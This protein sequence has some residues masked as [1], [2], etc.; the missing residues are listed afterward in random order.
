MYFEA[1]RP[2]TVNSVALACRNN[3]VEA[4]KVMISEGCGRD[5]LRHKDN[6]GWEPIHEPC[7][8]GAIESLRILLEEDETEI[9]AESWAGETGLN[10]AASLQNR[11]QVAKVLLE[12]GCDV[13]SSDEMGI[14]PLHN[15]TIRL[16]RP[17]VDLLTERG[18]DV[19]KKSVWNTTSLHS[20]FKK[21][22][23]EDES[24]VVYILKKLVKHG[25]EVDSGDEN[26][27]TPL[28]IAAEKG[29]LEVCKFLLDTNIRLLNMEAE[30]GANALMLACQNGHAEVVD[31]LLAMSDAHPEYGI[32]V[33]RRASDGAMALHLAAEAKAKSSEIMKMV[34]SRTDKDQ[35]LS[36][37]K[38]SPYHIALEHKNLE[39][40]S[41]LANSN[42]LHP[43]QFHVPIDYVDNDYLIWSGYS[44]LNSLGFLLTN[45]ASVPESDLKKLL[46]DLEP[47][48]ADN[49]IQSLPPILAIVLHREGFHRNLRRK[50]SSSEYEN[51]KIIL[52]F[53]HEKKIRIEKDS[54]SFLLAFGHTL[55]IFLLFTEGFIT[56]SDLIDVD[57]LENSLLIAGKSELPPGWTGKLLYLYSKLSFLSQQI[58]SVLK[59]KFNNL[60][61]SKSRTLQSLARAKI[62][63]SIKGEGLTRQKV[64]VLGLPHTLE[65]YLLYCDVESRMR[66]DLIGFS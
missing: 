61:V 50:Y 31:Y 56:A 44:K 28:I 34:L 41:L 4:L 40:V 52:R 13:N 6:R 53:F 2:E 42:I 9:D 35:V 64:S 7:H 29:F 46:E 27:L 39:T 47:C 14:S 32:D 16:D 20:V 49:K 59:P 62:H 37:R 8:A 12:S 30:D 19:N 1:A 51:K 21:A 3:D 36:V 15:A 63:L 11:L 26:D 55:D 33:N 10:I 5:G 54:I 48:L 23:P 18:A 43:Q 60:Y 57:V 22:S 24:T 17:L 66:E 25:G 38:H 45:C 58:T 65:D